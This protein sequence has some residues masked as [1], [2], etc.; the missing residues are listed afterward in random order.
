MAERLDDN[1]RD[2]VYSNGERVQVLRWTGSRAFIS[3]NAT[4][5]RVALPAGAEMIE[6]VATESCYI[7][8]GDVTVDATAAIN[9]TSRLFTA[10]VQQVPVP[11]DPATDEPYTYVAAIEAA[12]TTPGILQIEELA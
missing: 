12:A 4:S 5:A 11:I 10:G 7:A 2:Y 9:A 8:F 3:F 6:L 1:A